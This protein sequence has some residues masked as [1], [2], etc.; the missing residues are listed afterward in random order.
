MTMENATYPGLPVIPPLPP[1]TGS[2]A[3]PLTDKTSAAFKTLKK[4]VHALRLRGDP[5]ADD[6]WD[7]VS[8]LS[9]SFTPSA[10]PTENK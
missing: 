5:M 4:C 7:A 3:V 9:W 6:I 8:I 2:L 10:K 1:S